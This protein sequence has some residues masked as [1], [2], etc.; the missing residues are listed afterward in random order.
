MEILK[1]VLVLICLLIGKKLCY[2]KKSMKK[3]HLS[4][5]GCAMEQ[6]YQ[7]TSQPTADN[8]REPKNCLTMVALVGTGQS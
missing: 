6:Q 4:Y 8:R 5:L 3:E 7:Q 1:L 2:I